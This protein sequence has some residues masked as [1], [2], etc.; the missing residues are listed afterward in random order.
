MPHVHLRVLLSQNRDR[1]GVLRVEQD[2]R[3]IAE[4]LAFDVAAGAL[5]IRAC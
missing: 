2:G 4:F 1:T 5:V 3:V